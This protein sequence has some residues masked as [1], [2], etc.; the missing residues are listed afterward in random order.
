MVERIYSVI[1]WMRSVP[2]EEVPGTDLRTPHEE[3]VGIIEQFGPAI[4]SDYDNLDTRIRL[5]GADRT[6]LCGGIYVSTSVSDIQLINN[7]IIQQTRLVFTGYNRR[8]GLV[9]SIQKFYNQFEN[10]ERK[11]KTVK[12]AITGL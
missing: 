1:D 4:L 3:L 2:F 10:V 5:R 8:L 6:Y 12:K 7:P 9:G 11:E